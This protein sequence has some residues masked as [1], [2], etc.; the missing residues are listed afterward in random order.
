MTQELG[1]NPIRPARVT[2]SSKSS[3]SIDS[4]D[5]KWKAESSTCAVEVYVSLRG[6]RHMQLSR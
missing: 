6:K 2:Q 1:L 5:V 3:W 4:S